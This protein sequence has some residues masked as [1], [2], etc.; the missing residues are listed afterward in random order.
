MNEESN[1]IS[2]STIEMLLQLDHPNVIK[3]Y[4]I[5]EDLNNIYI[6][7]EYCEGSDLFHFI[8]SRKLFSEEL[9]KAIIKQILEALLYLHLNSI[10]HRDVKPENILIFNKDFTN[11]SDIV[12]KLSDFTSATLIK[13][14]SKIKSKAIGSPLYIAP[15]VL[16]GKFDKHCD[17]WSVGVITYTM[18]CGRPPFTGKEYEIL[19]KILNEDLE[20]ASSHSEAA[21]EFINLLTIKDPNKRMNV[22]HALSHHWL[23]E[24]KEENFFKKDE[25]KSSESENKESGIAILSEMSKFVMGKNL[26][27]SVLSYIM[28]SKF[29]VEKRDD[30][31]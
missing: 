13:A 27:R 2:E 25:K 20:F 14:R 28:S 9:V 10:V 8:L 26:K 21:R 5:V 29:Y 22:K 3:I 7:Q 15:E 30:L 6:V 11:I 4:D 31:F 1:G 16:E 12:I 23:N 19:Y 18:L 17:L 24:L